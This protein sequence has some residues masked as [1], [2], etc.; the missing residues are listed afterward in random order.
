MCKSKSHGGMRCPAGLKERME[1]IAVQME[2]LEE[3]KRS[4]ESADPVSQRSRQKLAYI[5]ERLAAYRQKLAILEYDYDETADGQRWLEK[6]IRNPETPEAERE[7]Y[8]FRLTKVREDSAVQKRFVNE[9]RTKIQNT[10]RAMAQAGFSEEDAQAIT[11]RFLTRDMNKLP[12]STVE[13]FN[14]RKAAMEERDALIAS[15]YRMKTEVMRSDDLDADDKKEAHQEIDDD[16]AAELAIL[17]ERVRLAKQKYD[18]TP[19]GLEFLKKGYGRLVA[20]GKISEAS[21]ISVRIRLAEREIRA[22]SDERNARGSMKRAIYKAAKKAGSDPQ[23]VWDACKS[24]KAV[25]LDGTAYS[26][27]ESTDTLV[28]SPSVHLTRSDYS[29]LTAEVS[30][31]EEYRSVPVQDAVKDLVRKRIMEDPISRQQGKSLEQSNSE[32]D[33]ARDGSVGRYRTSSEELRDTRTYPSL[34]HKEYTEV[35]AIA[36]TLE[37]TPSSYMRAMA[38][39]K[40]FSPFAIQNDRSMRGNWNRKV[41]ASQNYLAN[42]G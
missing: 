25:N 32:A 18:A 4:L 11:E 37:M 39:G 7:M 19:A 5:E 40:R 35:K 27:R 8:R 17:N 31:M 6:Q 12:F 28:K 2:E 16:H 42:A 38:L 29:S 1:T 15:I 26:T 33:T 14:E 20:T 24:I 23:A 22:R 41:T 36:K 21:E 13:A 30:T 34:T 9:N 3:T 10:K